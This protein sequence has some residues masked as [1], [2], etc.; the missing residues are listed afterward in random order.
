MLAQGGW[1]IDRGICLQARRVCRQCRG[2]RFQRP[3]LEREREG[4]AD[5]GGGGGGGGV[6]LAGGKER[7]RLEYLCGGFHNRR[8]GRVGAVVEDFRKWRSVTVK[9]AGRLYAGMAVAAAAA[10]SERGYTYMHVDV[11]VEVWR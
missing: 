9:D 6:G 5:G 7:G 2:C 10:A 3:S 11:A 4:R 8:M 1:P